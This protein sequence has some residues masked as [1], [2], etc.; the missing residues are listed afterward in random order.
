LR[1][2]FC[3]ATPQYEKFCTQCGR[4]LLIALTQSVPKQG[5]GLRFLLVFIFAVAIAGFVGLTIVLQKSSS[6]PASAKNLAKGP[7]ENAPPPKPE[8]KAE[9]KKE[10]A[11]L[12][13]LN[14]ALRVAYAKDVEDR[15]LAQGINCD[16][17]ATGP[18]HTI[19]KFKWAL[20]SKVTAYQFAHS[21]GDMW[22]A[23]EKLGF[24]RFIV[25]DGYD[26]EWYW[27]LHP[28]RHGA[29]K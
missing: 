8:S 27:T 28:I 26:E 16:V 25:T 15:M 9:L 10:A 14:D 1:C 22:T 4:P 13:V 17:V 21:E 5:R 12:A 3:Q 29:A 2:P 6:Q 20:V 24:T 19:L 7:L 23:M 18:K 11:A